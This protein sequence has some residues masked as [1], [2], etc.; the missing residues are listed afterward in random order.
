MLENAAP[1][2]PALPGEPIRLVFLVLTPQVWPTLKPIWELASRDDRFHTKVVLLENAT[3]EDGLSGLLA[4]RT[5]LENQHVPFVQGNAFSLERYTPHV[6]FLPLPYPN[7]YPRNCTPDAVRACGARIAYVPY[8]LEVGGGAYNARYQYDEPVIRD[9]WRVFAR[10][11]TQLQ[12]FGR[13]CATGNAQV[14]VTG[15]PRADERP[16]QDIQ[17]DQAVLERAADRKIVIWAPHFSVTTRRKWSSF[18]ENHET[19]LEEI[20]SRQDL[21]FVLRPHP[22]LERTLRQAKG[23]SAEKA[24]NWF[25]ELDAI[26]NLYVDKAAEYWP[27]FNSS[28]A[29]MSDS[30]SFLV[31]YLLTGKPICHLLGKD[32][33]GLTD[34]A[35]Q[36]AAF[37][38]GTS[39]QEISDFL[40]QV[41]TGKDVLEEARKSARETYFGSFEE[42]AAP[43]I[44]DE[45]IRGINDRPFVDVLASY[46]EKHEAAFSYWKSAQ[47]TFLAPPEYYD[48]QEELMTAL[49]ER[50]PPAGFAVDIGCGNGRY[51]EVLAKFCDHVEGVDPGPALIEEAKA[52]AEGKSIENIEYRIERLERLE[53]VASYDLVCCMGVLSGLIDNDAF[54]KATR[55]LLSATKPGGMILLKDSLSIGAPQATEWNGYTAVY[56]NIDD[57][58]SSF[59]TL[60]LEMIEEVTIAPVNEKGLTNRFF[61]FRRTNGSR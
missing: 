9:A 3:P 31:E 53:L 2:T 54:L 24:R 7:L 12:S 14:V 58:L 40:N 39:G 60:G 22:L 46:S 35:H 1:W 6:V 49:L 47:T 25:L 29:L 41:E 20:K 56:R 42:Q 21:F 43:R 50:H 10:S 33:I 11:H 61:L 19:M 16:T 37:H 48:K 38:P 51:T 32:A 4:A 57:Y 59:R 15:H 8:G 36:L 44:L 45:I 52:R 55:T 17:L 5:M 28:A 26:P 23:W 27:T 18:L 13:H 30:G 34:E